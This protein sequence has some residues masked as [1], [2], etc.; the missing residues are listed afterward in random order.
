MA[1]NRAGDPRRRPLRGE[2]PPPRARRPLPRRELP[3]GETFFTPGA[4]GLR[5][6]VERRAAAPLLFLYQLPRW[7]V[8]AAL[9]VTLVIGF[10]VPGWGGAAALVLLAAVLGGFAYLSWPN[11]ASRGRLL[12]GAA[13]A[14]LIVLA[15]TQA[16]R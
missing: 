11:L 2:A 12:R 7:V 8:P 13:V 10:A 3:R 15:I 6:A 4:S 1:A 9:L 14:I 5:Q 16:T